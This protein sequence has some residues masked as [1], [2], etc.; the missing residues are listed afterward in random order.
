MVRFLPE[1]IISP[2]IK[3][4][5]DTV[6]PSHEAFIGLRIKIPYI[7]LTGDVPFSSFLFRL[8]CSLVPCLPEKKKK[9]KHSTN[10]TSSSSL[11]IHHFR[12]HT[13]WFGWQFHCLIFPKPNAPLGRSHHWRTAEESS[14]RSHESLA[15]LSEEIPHMPCLQCV[16][17]TSI[18]S[19]S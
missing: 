4:K 19:G 15:F 18:G 2:Q 10:C 6:K 13:G 17:N 11:H 9:K 12:K 5:T 16:W 3:N 14:G 7:L 1:V 8:F